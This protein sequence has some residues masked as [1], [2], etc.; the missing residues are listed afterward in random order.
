[1]VKTSQMLV[2]PNIAKSVTTGTANK[3]LYITIHET[4]NTNRGSNANAHARL[5]A[6]GNSRQASWHWQVDDKEAI[7][8]FPHNYQCWHAGS[9]NGNNQSIGVEICVNSDG[10]YQKALQNAAELVR[11]IMKQE[12]IPIQNVVQ[13]NHWS[14]KNCPRN[15]RASGWGE[16]IQLIR[17]AG[18]VKAASVNKEEV[19]MFKP[20]NATF[21]NEAIGMLELAKEMEIISSDEHAEKVRN[22]EMSLDDMVALNAAVIRRHLESVKKD[23]K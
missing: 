11:N 2:A 13:H 1:M 3:K 12:N 15:L 14:G 10:D 18:E 16:F 9:T 7:Q 22:N 23:M 20:S 17:K 5:Q 19:R 6:N 4:D 8:S 21:K